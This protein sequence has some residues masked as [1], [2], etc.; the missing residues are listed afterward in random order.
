M[1]LA[2]SPTELRGLMPKE[3]NR[4]MVALVEA[5]PKAGETLPSYRIRGVGLGKEVSLKVEV[6]AR[7]GGMGTR[8]GIQSPRHSLSRQIGVGMP[9]G[10]MGVK[11]SEDRGVEGETVEDA[12]K[13]EE[14]GALEGNAVPYTPSESVIP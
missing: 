3:V 4:A 1:C 6:M 7:E 9:P 14:A 5:N 12:E 2:T 11:V 13:E 10:G 8:E